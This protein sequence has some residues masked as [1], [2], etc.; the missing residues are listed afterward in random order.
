MASKIQQDANDP[1]AIAK[2][3]AQNAAD[4]G[5]AKAMEDGSISREE[6][7]EIDQMRRDAHRKAIM[8]SRGG[9]E[10]FSPEQIADA[11][12]QNA[13]ATVQSLQAAGKTS[14]DTT[15]A[16]AQ[17]LNVTQQFDQMQQKQQQQIDHALKILAGIGN[18]SRRR[19]QT[20]GAKGI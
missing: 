5:T 17:V 3:L 12:S 6:Q 2:R 13:Q 9:P 7:K 14:Q 4:A 11:A 16:L 8:Q 19:A 10:S 20:M 18:N 15:Q 1:R